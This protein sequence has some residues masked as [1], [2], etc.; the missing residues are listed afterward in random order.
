VVAGRAARVAR[1]GAEPWPTSAAIE[2]ILDQAAA[3]VTL[4]EQQIVR[5]FQARG[6]DF[7]AVCSAADA[8]RK[9]TVGDV[10]RYVVNRNINYTNVCT[11][12]CRFCAFSK[13]KLSYN[14]RGEPYDL[15]LDE[16]VRRVHEA[17]Q[18][19]A[20]EVCMQ[21]GIHPDYTGDTYI[22]LCRAVNRPFPAC[23]SMP[24][25]RWK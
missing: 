17:W 2:H 18:R 20:T 5:L 10:V 1:A 21:G 12:R 24:S 15:A 7:D 11:F 13:G 14:L 8:L 3:G 19:G 22:E 9:Q 23:M 4:E 25:R 6:P 16:V